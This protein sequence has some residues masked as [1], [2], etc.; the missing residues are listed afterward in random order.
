MKIVNM[1]STAEKYTL[2]FLMIKASITCEQ[3]NMKAKV[4]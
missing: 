2:T 3:K 1:K 4:R